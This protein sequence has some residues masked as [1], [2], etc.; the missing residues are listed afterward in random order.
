[1]TP[2]PVQGSP[3]FTVLTAGILHTCGLTTDGVAWCWGANGSGQLGSF[4][5]NASAVPIRVS[6]PHR[7]R[8]ISAGGYG[9]CGITPDD[10]MFC[11]GDG[12]NE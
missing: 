12:F 2:V 4:L 5:S 10:E 9:T 6:A 7:W 8:S 11:W 3:A 1:M